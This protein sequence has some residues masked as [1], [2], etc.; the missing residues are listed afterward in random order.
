MKLLHLVIVNFL[1]PLY[2]FLPILFNF[3]WFTLAIHK[4]WNFHYV[5]HQTPRH[6]GALVRRTDGSDVSIKPRKNQLD[7]LPFFLK[8]GA[9]LARAFG[10]RRSSAK[11]RTLLIVVCRQFCF[12]VLSSASL[13][14]DIF[15]ETLPQICDAKTVSPTFPE[16]SLACSWMTLVTISIETWKR[17]WR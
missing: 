10:P 14:I 15:R 12:K 3:K 7:G 16:R 8:Y 5:G 9:P 17:E 2:E 13:R 11:N 4:R 6:L 1:S